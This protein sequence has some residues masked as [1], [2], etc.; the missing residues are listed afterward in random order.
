MAYPSCGARSAAPTRATRTAPVVASCALELAVGQEPTD[1][2][3]LTLVLP[4]WTP[5]AGLPPRQPVTAGKPAEADDPFVVRPCL[6]PALESHTPPAVGRVERVPLDAGRE[7]IQ[8]SVGTRPGLVEYAVGLCALLE[9]E[10]NRL[11]LLSV[12][13]VDGDLA[14]GLTQYRRARFGSLEVLLQA[15][16]SGPESE[17]PDVGSYDSISRVTPAGPRVIGAMWQRRASNPPFWSGRYDWHM[18]SAGVEPD[19]RGYVV[20]ERWEF[21]ERN[22]QRVTRRAVTR[23]YTIGHDQVVVTPPDELN[24]WPETSTEGW[25]EAGQ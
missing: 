19:G 17:E 10:P 4:E 11:R 7:L 22:T 16:T 14:K 23:R 5:D 21:T 13:E 20:H 15:V 24:A 1:A 18:T 25:P 3:L 6:G 9:R 2:E 8:F 12:N